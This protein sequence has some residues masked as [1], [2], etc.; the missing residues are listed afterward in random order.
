M[1]TR[2]KAANPPSQPDLSTETF[3]EFIES[4]KVPHGKQNLHCCTCRHEIQL[5]Q[6]LNDYLAIQ[7]QCDALTSRD[8]F[9]EGSMANS[10]ASSIPKWF[11]PPTSAKRFM[12][13]PKH[14]QFCKELRLLLKPPEKSL[15]SQP[16]PTNN[17]IPMGIPRRVFPE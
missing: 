16:P 14:S 2:S 7:G 17:P 10:A 11:L 3:E 8:K 5:S 1:N 15:R 13:G 6:L 4:S 9:L 12:H